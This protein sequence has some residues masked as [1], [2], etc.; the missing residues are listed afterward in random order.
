MGSQ[1]Q[2][3]GPEGK[4]YSG[5]PQTESDEGVREQPNEVGGMCVRLYVVV[6]YMCLFV[7]L[8]LCMILELF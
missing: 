1:G 2:W 7:R 6:R 5:V 3:A 8:Y 4:L